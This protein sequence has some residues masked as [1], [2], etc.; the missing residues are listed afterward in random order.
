MIYGDYGLVLEILGT[1]F[2]CRTMEKVLH[3]CYEQNK[4]C[5]GYCCIMIYPQ[6]SRGEPTFNLAYHFV[7]RNLDR[8]KLGWFASASWY[9]GPRL[10]HHKGLKRFNGW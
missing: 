2:S 3:S 7:I 10:R 1:H 5:S 6:T 9:L 8:P 4:H